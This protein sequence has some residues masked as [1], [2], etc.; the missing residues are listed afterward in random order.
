MVTYPNCKINLGLNITSLREDGYHNI[1]TVLYPVPFHDALEIIPAKDGIFEFH[2]SG[3]SIPGN[4]GDNLCVRA[5]N[6][7]QQDFRLPAVR[8]HLHKII[9]MGA[10]LGGG[11]SDGAFALKLLN[12]LF[13]IGLNSVQLENYARKLGSDCAFFIENIPCF[14]FDKGDRFEP[15]HVDLS[16]LTIVL[17]IPGVHVGTREAY[18]MISPA[19]PEKRIKESVLWP[20]GDWKAALGNDFEKPVIEKYPVIGKAKR[21]LYEMGALYAAMSGS[22]SAVFAIFREPP[23]TELAFP[24]CSVWMS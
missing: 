14:A 13:D 8:M 11:S 24:G 17:V 15:V 21:A 23:A 22:G 10:G 6:L 4:P 9:P 19:I 2:T 3:L 16:A 20:V 1:E 12:H 18:A 7:L 5:Y